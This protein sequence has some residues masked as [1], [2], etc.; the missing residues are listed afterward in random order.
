MANLLF[1]G[2]IIELA[3][4]FEYPVARIEELGNAGAAACLL[5][6]RLMEMRG[7]IQPN[8]ISPLL[9]ALHRL[10]KLGIEKSVRDLFKS[11]TGI[12]YTE[13]YS[14]TPINGKLKMIC[15]RYTILI[16]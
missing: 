14:E 15:I 9:H 1:M 12:H 2:V 4:F 8:D 6:V 3:T 16:L 13:G 10:D 7:Q 11:H 5:M